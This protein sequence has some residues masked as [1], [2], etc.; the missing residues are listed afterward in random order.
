MLLDFFVEAPGRGRAAGAPHAPLVHR[1]RRL[2]R[3][4]PGL[5]HRRRGGRALRHGRR[6][7]AAAAERFARLPLADLVAPAAAHARDG[8]EVNAQQAYLFEIL[9]PICRATPAA[10]A[11][12][13]PAGRAPRVGEVHRDP[14]LADALERLAREGAAPF[15]TGDVAAAVCAHVAERGGLLTADDLAA[16]DAVPRAPGAGRLPRHDRGHQPAAERGRHTARA[17]AARARRARRRRPACPRCSPRWRRRSARR[18]HAR[19]SSSGCGSHDP[20]LRDGRGRV[21]VRGDVH[22]R[23]GLRRGRARHGRPPQ[24]HDGRAGPLAVRLLHPSAG[25]PAAVDDGADDGVRRRTG[26]RCRSAP[27][28]RTGSAPRSSRSSSACS[29]AGSTC[30]RRSTRRALHVEDGIVYLEPGVDEAGLEDRTLV[31]FQA[32]NLFFGGA[33]AVERAGDE[34]RGGGDFRRGGGVAVA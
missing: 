27:P 18:A 2:R 23:R 33:Q 11:L 14:V 30:R 19:S 25:A 9:A 7:R 28:A 29:T 15:Y 13:Q 1:R 32:P 5:P 3:R 17:R 6:A 34:L 16:Y 21:G 26:R 12:Y 24:Q 4:G 31:R 20:H 8:V 10:R 22:E